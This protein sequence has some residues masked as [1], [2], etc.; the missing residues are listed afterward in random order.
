MDLTI[1]TDEDLD[2]L[3]I[4]V[5]TEHERRQRIRDAAELTQTIADRHAADV[6]D[7]PARNIADVEQ[8]EAIGPGGRVII[9][10]TEWINATAAWLSPHA[11]GPDAYPLGWRLGNPPSPDDPEVDEWAPDMQV[12]AAGDPNNP[13]D[14]ATLVAHDGV[15]Y[16]AIQSHRT[17][18]G[19]EPPN[20]PALWTL[21]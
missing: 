17:Q 11:A 13:N 21:A 18:A 4:A 8:H 14:G 1:L 20:V 10:G 3:R 5:L 19:W 12:W 16:K 9:G 6:A 15:V 7:D 2:D